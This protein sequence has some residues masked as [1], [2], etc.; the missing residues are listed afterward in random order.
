[1]DIARTMKNKTINF[2]SG[3]NLLKKF[4]FSKDFLIFN[5]L[6]IVH[7]ATRTT[8]KAKIILNIKKREIP[9]NII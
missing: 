4:N 3:F 7:I 5:H 6:L 9:K 1:M 2:F 8:E